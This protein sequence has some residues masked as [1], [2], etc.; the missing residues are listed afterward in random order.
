MAMLDEV[1]VDSSRG[2][3]ISQAASRQEKCAKRASAESHSTDVVKWH[4]V[5]VAWCGGKLHNVDMAPTW[6]VLFLKGKGRKE[7]LWGGGNAQRCTPCGN[8]Y[9]G[10]GGG[11][12]GRKDFFLLKG[13][14]T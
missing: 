10:G 7:K 1:S 4:S 8:I 3:G 11:G 6:K 5:A 9:M 12:R 14:F 2:L 13:V